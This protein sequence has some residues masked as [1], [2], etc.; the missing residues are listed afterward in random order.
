MFEMMLHWLTEYRAVI[1]LILHVLVPFLVAIIGSKLCANVEHKKRWLFVFIVLMLTMLV[2]IDHLIADPI[3]APGRCSIWF[4][5]LHTFWPMLVYVCMMLWPLLLKIRIVK[6][7]VHGALNK[8]YVVGLLG[9]GLVIHMLLD[10]FD[11]LWMR[12]C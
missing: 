8:H 7:N 10:W 11:C 12:A 2:D 3:Y 5:P 6:R 9:L 4:H 1:H